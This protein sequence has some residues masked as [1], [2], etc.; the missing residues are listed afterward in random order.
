[1]SSYAEMSF[2]N[3]KSL[4]MVKQIFWFEIGRYGVQKIHNFT[5]ISKWGVLSLH[6]ARS[7]VRAKQF[8]RE[9]PITSLLIFEKSGHFR[10][11]VTSRLIKMIVC[12]DH[13]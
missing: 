11:F 6:L 2:Q 1:M 10:F 13:Y 8:F 5:L 12:N 9:V 7:K 4:N 3:K